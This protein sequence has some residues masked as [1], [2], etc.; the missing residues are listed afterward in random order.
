MTTNIQFGVHTMMWG[1]RLTRDRLLQMLVDIAEVAGEF[2]CKEVGVEFGQK[3][4]HL[5]YDLPAQRRSGRDRRENTLHDGFVEKRDPHAVPRRG[6][7]KPI[8]IEDIPWGGR[9]VNYTQVDLFRDLFL[10]RNVYFKGRLKNKDFEGLIHFGEEKLPEGEQLPKLVLLGFSGRG[11]LEKRIKFCVEIYEATEQKITPKYFLIQQWYEVYQSDKKMAALIQRAHDWGAKLVLHPLRFGPKEKIHDFEQKLIDH[12]NLHFLADTAH[13][14]LA[15]KYI[16]KNFNWLLEEKLPNGTRLFDR[17]EAFHLKDWELM[18]DPSLRYYSRGFTELGAGCLSSHREDRTIISKDEDQRES[19][20][21]RFCRSLKE[22]DLEERR[23]VFEKDFT[24]Y[25]EKESLG[26]SFQWFRAIRGDSPVPQKDLKE[27]KGRRRPASVF[28]TKIPRT[29]DEKFDDR[30]R[31]V[32]DELHYRVPDN[33]EEFVKLL[34]E[35]FQFLFRDERKD[36]VDP[37]VFISLWECSPRLPAMV[38]LN[39]E[40]KIGDLTAKRSYLVNHENCTGFRV[41][42]LSK[43]DA[44]KDPEQQ[45][46]FDA[47]PIGKGKQVEVGGCDTVLWIPICNSYNFNQVEAAINIFVKDSQLPVL[48]GVKYANEGD[49][50]KLHEGYQYKLEAYLEDIVRHIG[51]ALEKMW[52][53]IASQVTSEL[54][55]KVCCSSDTNSMLETLKVALVES[56]CLDNKSSKD[57]M[58]IKPSR[59]FQFVPEDDRLEE[60]VPIGYPYPRMVPSKNSAC[61]VAK[62]RMDFVVE[63]EPFS[64]LDKTKIANQDVPMRNLYSLFF[65][66]YGKRNF[67]LGTDQNAIPDVVAVVECNRV[68]RA[69]SSSEENTIREILFGFMPY[70]IHCL[71]S[72]NRERAIKFTRHELAHPIHALR[73]LTRVIKDNMEFKSPHARRH[74]YPGEWQTYIDILDGIVKS[75]FHIT[76]QDL[77]RDRETVHGIHGKIIMPIVHQGPYLIDK[78]LH[79]DVIEEIKN[80]QAIRV[81]YAGPDSNF[82]DS[83]LG[84]HSLQDRKLYVSKSLFFLVFFNLLNNA[85]K[86]SQRLPIQ[87][88]HEKY[89]HDIGIDDSVRRMQID[90]FVEVLP[91]KGDPKYKDDQEYPGG[92]QVQFCDYGPGIGSWYNETIFREGVREPHLGSK[93]SGEGIGLW[94]VRKIVEAHGGRITLKKNE[95]PTTFCMQFPK[96]IFY[97]PKE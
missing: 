55:E 16:R 86:F 23:I 54:I 44:K 76:D 32:I 67:G 52:G 51:L 53:N 73:S 6:T 47:Y 30:K 2:G 12:P 11:C 48:D 39:K 36:G 17:I 3:I 74:D 63:Q 94:V 59:I 78:K 82:E 19:V 13:L 57:E 25:D 60:I 95:S 49:A 79:E 72:D 70:Y 93:L 42:E 66:L 40:E 35:L 33:S 46:F 14:W 71:A 85:L 38:L 62:K 75:S 28:S 5:G 15:N 80:K 88:L 96:D 83:R 77:S 9:I 18:Y 24:D 91:E 64:P 92:L 84:S 45:A 65:P 7:R 31:Q 41:W 43:L 50:S 22:E 61:Y 69:F 10:G 4:H 1:K 56:F 97:P 68:D 81:F 8:P 90:I 87:D 27:L 37:P 34:Q 26:Q 89:E 20:L 21:G 58:D 29:G